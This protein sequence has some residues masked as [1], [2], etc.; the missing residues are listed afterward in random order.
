MCGFFQEAIIRQPLAFCL[1]SAV[2]CGFTGKPGAIKKP[3][4][5]SIP[6]H[7]PLDSDTLK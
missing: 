4:R 5:L 7:S 1:R 6:A 2:F 3:E